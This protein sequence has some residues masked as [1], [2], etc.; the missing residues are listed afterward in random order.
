MSWLKISFCDYLPGTAS[1][2]QFPRKRRKIV[3][4][5]W[6]VFDKEDKTPGSRKVLFS[7]GDIAECYAY[8]EGARDAIPPM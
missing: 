5:Q 2:S 4:G 3:P 8:V 1:V 6:Y 7:S